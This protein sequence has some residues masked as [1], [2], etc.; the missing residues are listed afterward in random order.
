MEKIEKVGLIVKRTPEARRVAQEIVKYL[1]ER[2]I[3]VVYDA[4][5]ARDLGAEGCEIEAMQVDLYLVLG[6]DGMMLKAA[7]RGAGDRAPVLGFNFG[8]M[9]FLTEA[10]P[11]EWRSTLEKVLAGGGYVE[12][13]SKLAVLVRGRRVGEALNEAVV[14]SA[15]PVKMLH[16]EVYVDG[17]LAQVLRSDGVIV[18]TPTGSTAYS[19]SA[20]GPIIDPRTRA[21]VITP[22]CPF[23]S[24]A[25]SVVIPENLTVKIK[26]VDAK[27]R[28]LLVIDGQRVLELKAGE[29]VILKKSSSV[30][31][32]L[33]LKDDYYE[34][35]RERL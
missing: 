7:S 26:L 9:G 5:C 17:A 32:L 15:S 33:K 14:A 28:A 23:S 29:E 22:I 6:G 24:S 19:M 27:E 4:E 3:D 31:K 16:L 21:V 20:G 18:A 2:D 8:M 13:R 30:V 10:K 12:E 35:I 34:R 25:R 1:A 11:E